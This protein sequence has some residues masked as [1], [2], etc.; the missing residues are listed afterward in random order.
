MAVLQAARAYV[1]GLPIDSA[2]SWGLNRAIFYAAAKRGFKGGGG[3]SGS[4][5]ASSTSRGHSGSK[6][7][8]RVG[9]NDY[10]L[11]DE[12]AYRDDDS[13]SEQP[14]F[15]IG[16]KPQTE[17]NF[18]RQIESRFQETPFED[19][20][21]EALDYVGKFDRSVLESGSRFYSDVYR[22]RRD[23][24]SGKWSRAKPIR[25]PGSGKQLSSTGA[26]KMSRKTRG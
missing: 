11:G 21:K 3:T 26:G 1:L 22:P 2:H 23:E 8:K 14:V 4:G 12:A 17:D 5:S 19:A 16:G 25:E 13:S 9:V 24:L 6:G 10:F 15:V 18:Q 20:W 7:Q